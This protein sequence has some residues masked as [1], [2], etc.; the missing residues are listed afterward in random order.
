[1]AHCGAR[2]A[3]LGV[4]ILASG[5]V[6]DGST[7]LPAEP[8]GSRAAR[9]VLALLARRGLTSVV[10][11]AG[12]IILARL[13]EP[14]D[15]G[16]FAVITSVF[17]ILNSIG[18][19][20]LAATL[21]RQRTEP[22]RRELDAVF[23]AQQVMSGGLCVVLGAVLLAVGGH[24]NGSYTFLLVCVIGAIL[25]TSPQIVAV[26]QLERRL[27]FT[28]LGLIGI[29]ESVVFYGVAVTL[30]YVGVGVR[31]FGIALVVQAV[32]G[33]V[34]YVSASHYSPGFAWTGADLRERYAFGI[35]FQGVELVSLSKDA[36]TPVFV[37]LILGARDVGLITWANQVSAY[38]LLAL[39][40]LS[41]LYMPIFARLQDDP[42]RL[43]VAVE[44]TIF[45]ANV[46]T[47][48]VA[49]FV[50][51]YIQP[52]V[53]VVY[54]SKWHPAIP[55]LYV[56]WSANLLVPTATPLLALITTCGQPGFALK[57][58]LIWML[59]TWLIGAPLILATGAIGFAIANLAVQATNAILFARA[60]SLLP[61]VRLTRAAAPPWIA[62]AFA[63]PLLLLME[64][65]CAPHNAFE[66]G[67]SALVWVVAYGGLC[68]VVFRAR[69]A[70]FL[71]LIRRVERWA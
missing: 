1:L 42:A 26:A 15:F 52:L 20:G 64:L 16:A 10:A 21:V 40:A 49:I 60:R 18:D 31:S 55:L 58:A 57:M 62:A 56:I 45:L 46:V 34:M 8:L 19:G 47:V 59:G 13:L 63:A 68:A 37:G 14:R 70:E 12:S 9:G 53:H 61:A 2:S 4:S 6:P 25:C 54:G 69:T 43:T 67:A 7:V 48:P 23:T 44:K 65:F 24:L 50:L 29:C 71:R 32:V 5:V 27:D 35:P 3:E 11:V 17:G 38:A 30:A 28:R 22:T 33:T 66:V 51:V 39:M 36:F 41:K